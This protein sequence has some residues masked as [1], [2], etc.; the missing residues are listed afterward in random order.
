M[1][2]IHRYDSTILRRGT[3]MNGCVAIL[4]LTR[5]PFF[6]QVQILVRAWEK[7]LE[8]LSSPDAESIVKVLLRSQNKIVKVEHAV[9]ETH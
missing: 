5:K 7:P 1:V 9:S 3:E 6:P 2:P 8:G 4:K